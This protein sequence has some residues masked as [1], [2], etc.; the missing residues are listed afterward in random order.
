MSHLGFSVEFE[1]PERA[2]L[3]VAAL[4]DD[5]GLTL[6]LHQTGEPTQSGQAAYIQ[7]DDVEATFQRLSNAGI[8]FSI[9]PSKQFWGYGA[10]LRDPDGHVL[11][12]WDETSMAAKG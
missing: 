10:T 9:A 12:L 7:V 2:G 11:H 1:V 6:F 4:Q 8:V 3:G 5:S